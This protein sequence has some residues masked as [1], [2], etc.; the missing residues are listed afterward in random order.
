[1]NGGIATTAVVCTIEPDLP[2]IV[3]TREGP[4]AAQGEE[5]SVRWLVVKVAA[6]LKDEPGAP[7]ME[8]ETSPLNPK[9]GVTVTVTEAVHELAGR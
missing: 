2:V 6:G 3:R 9:S 8:S 4:P 1:L 7:A 5:R